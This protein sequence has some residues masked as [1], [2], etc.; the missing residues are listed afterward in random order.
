[1]LCVMLCTRWW[2]VMRQI[3]A[4]QEWDSFVCKDAVGRVGNVQVLTLCGV[5][6]RRKGRQLGRELRA[7]NRCGCTVEARICC[8]I[9]EGMLGTT[10]D[11]WGC[12]LSRGDGQWGAG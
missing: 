7:A 2:D 6:E 4:H 8:S 10:W 11:G 12:C 3:R 1:M 5:Q 9:G